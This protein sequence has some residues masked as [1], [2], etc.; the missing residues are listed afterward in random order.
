[1]SKLSPEKSIWITNISKK[2]VCLTDLAFTVPA[3]KSFDLLSSHFHLTEAQIRTSIESGSIAKKSAFIKVRKIP[4]VPLPAQNI[5]ISL[6]P[7]NFGP[8]R[9]QVKVE[10]K[11]Y[12]ELML[13]DE[14]FA[15]EFSAIDETFSDKVAEKTV[16][17]K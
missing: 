8:C 17:S 9:S 15:E 13:S 6:E 16:K 14:N 7:W 1:M 11:Q 10:E 2:N 12:E 4:Y 5:E 3:G